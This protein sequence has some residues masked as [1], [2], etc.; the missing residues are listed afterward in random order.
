MIYIIATII[1]IVIIAVVAWYFLIYKK[2]QA[3]PI[4][5]PNV[6]AVSETLASYSSP[7]YNTQSL[8]NIPQS[9]TFNEI[10]VD[11][12]PIIETEYKLLKMARAPRPQPSFV[13]DSNLRKQGN[14][15]VGDLK[16]KPRTTGVSVPLIAEP[17]DLMVGYFSQ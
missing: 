12:D 7:Y 16:I 2:K 15:F 13:Y 5:K 14:P 17:S 9:T 1:I 10:T 3:T 8:S 4:K 6:P 11:E